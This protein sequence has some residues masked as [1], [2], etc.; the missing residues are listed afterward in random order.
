MPHAFLHTSIDAT[1]SHKEAINVATHS[2]GASW[3]FILDGFFVLVHEDVFLFSQDLTFIY[4]VHFCFY[5][6]LNPINPIPGG[7][8]AF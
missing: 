2:S 7:G 3:S 5:Q 1:N 8:G 6:H 4:S